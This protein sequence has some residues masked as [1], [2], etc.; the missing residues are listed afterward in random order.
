[1]HLQVSA[2]TPP[3]L[4]ALALKR[5]EYAPQ[6]E[7]DGLCI[8]EWQLNVTPARVSPSVVS[9]PCASLHHRSAFDAS[10][11]AF[12]HVTNAFETRVAT[13]LMYNAAQL[14]SV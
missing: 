6:V 4:P 3:G 2:R 10:A 5:I 11:K 1:M 14:K 13:L 9:Q 12:F 8:H 7:P